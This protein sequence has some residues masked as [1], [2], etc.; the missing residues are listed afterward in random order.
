M[1]QQR[2]RTSVRRAVVAG[3]PT[4]LVG[5]AAVELPAAFA[6]RL[7]DVAYGAG[8]FGDA[9]A[10][11]N[12]TF[13]TGAH[14]AAVLIAIGYFVVARRRAPE[15]QRWVVPA[16]WGWMSIMAG[17]ASAL[18][19]R[20]LDR[21]GPPAAPSPW[22]DTAPVAVAGLG[23][24]ALLGWWAAGPDPVPADA[25]A[26]PGRDAPRMELSDGE[27][28]LWSRTLFS[29]RGAVW[30]VCW[31]MLALVYLW[32]GGLDFAA[33]GFAASA[34][35]IGVQCWARVQVDGTGVRVV[36]PLFRRVL[37]GVSY[38][39]VIEAGPRVFDRS[40]LGPCVGYGV[41]HS[42]RLIG[43]RAR[44]GG[45]VLRLELSEGR[46][47]VVTVD[48]ADTAAAVVNTQLDRL[49]RERPAC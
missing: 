37:V 27:R 32:L 48:D 29:R 10:W 49:R 24:L 8:G 6:D 36:Q 4:V 40:V 28:L 21:P 47:F 18:V 7:P 19:V 9:Q 38:R 44:P 16:A 39:Q 1:D 42:G 22:W 5:L 30:A 17:H 2:R 31:A 43:Y 45:K 33:L 41:I 23:L 14:T 15:I 34:L 13:L 3:V 25:T 12:L 26:G 35:F 11:G 20:N 46:E